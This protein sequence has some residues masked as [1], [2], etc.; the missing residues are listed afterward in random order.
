MLYIFLRTISKSKHKCYRE[1]FVWCLSSYIVMAR[2][3]FWLWYRGGGLS[4]G[5]WC[6]TPLSTIFQLYRGWTR[7]SCITSGVF[8]VF[9]C[10]FVCLFICLFFCLFCITS[11]L[12]L[13]FAL[14]RSYFCFFVLHR[15]YFCFLYY[16]DLTS[17]LCI[18]SI[19]L[20]FFVSHGS[21]SSMHHWQS[22][23]K[24]PIW[25]SHVEVKCSSITC[26]C[27]WI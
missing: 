22:W 11:I 24:I 26:V 3:M 4:L 17:V 1:W 10:L 25:I 5:L 15:S 18:T 8:F 9:Y 21:T 7:F 14:H 23:C 20:L 2:T 19:L 16:I 27:P 12:L 6:L 13:F